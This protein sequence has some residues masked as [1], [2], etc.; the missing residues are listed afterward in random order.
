MEITTFE[1][2]TNFKR[3]NVFLGIVKEDMTPSILYFDGNN[4]IKFKREGP[5]RFK[6]DQIY[7]VV[8]AWDYYL[9]DEIKEYKICD[10]D[11]ICFTTIIPLRN[12]QNGIVHS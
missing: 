8:P 10:Y 3:E 2:G 5:I 4:F 12:Y 7:K 9:Y 1:I 11:M 6:I